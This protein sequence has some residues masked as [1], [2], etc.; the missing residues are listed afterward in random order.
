MLEKNN[1]LDDFIEFPNIDLL[2]PAIS[3]DQLLS[4]AKKRLSEF[5]FFGIVEQM[6]KSVELLCTTFGWN[7]PN[8]TPFLNQSKKPSHYILDEYTISKIKQ[9][10]ILDQKLYDYAKDLFQKRLC[11]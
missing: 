6:K 3:D 10:S 5:H 2:I 1:I 9:H 11:N 7:I 4:L 8:P